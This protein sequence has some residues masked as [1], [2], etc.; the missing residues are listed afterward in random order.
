MEVNFL[1]G[2]NQKE[3]VAVEVVAEWSM[4]ECNVQE[5]MS[6]HPTLPHKLGILSLLSSLRKGVL[7]INSKKR[8][9]DEQS[10]NLAR[11]CDYIYLPVPSQAGVTIWPHQKSGSIGRM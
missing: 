6:L 1:F 9:K 3:Y 8:M 7:K 11:W 4:F 2:M 10:M 5:D